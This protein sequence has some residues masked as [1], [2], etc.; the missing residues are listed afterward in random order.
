MICVVRLGDLQA[1]EQ[2]QVAA[3]AAIALHRIDHLAGVGLQR[4]EVLDAISRRGVHQAGAVLGADVLAADQQRS[5]VVEGMP[6]IDA[7]EQRLAGT[8]GDDARHSSL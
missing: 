2:R 1:A 4:I 3:E 6:R 5:A 8:A 7:F